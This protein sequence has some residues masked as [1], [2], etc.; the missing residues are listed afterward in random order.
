MAK[1]NKHTD[2]LFEALQVARGRMANAA[3]EKAAGNHI[4]SS[5]LLRITAYSLVAAIGEFLKGLGYEI[6]E[7]EP[8]GEDVGANPR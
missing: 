4:T 3:T 8:M 2:V 5:V 6:E 1:K 7:I